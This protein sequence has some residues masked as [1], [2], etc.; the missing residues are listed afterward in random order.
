MRS[1][2]RLKWNF[3]KIKKVDIK[4][5][6]FRYY[7]VLKKDEEIIES[8]KKFA[9]EN[10]IEGAKISGIGTLKNPELGFFDLE[11]KQYDKRILNGDFELLSLCGNISLFENDTIVHIHTLV[12]DSEFKAYGGHLFSSLVTGTAEIIIE[13][14]NERINRKHSSQENLNLIDF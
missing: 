9:I 3:M 13:T 10:S 2:F 4:G 11:K 8:L 6:F 7:V 5:D 1:T 12:S 14:A